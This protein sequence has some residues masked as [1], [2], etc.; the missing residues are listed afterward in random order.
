MWIPVDGHSE[1]QRERE[2]GHKNCTRKCVNDI[3]TD[4]QEKRGKDG[5]GGQDRRE[6]RG[7][8]EERR[9]DRVYIQDG[10]D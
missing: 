10:I 2:G 7:V 9:D 3:T 4:L 1:G 5:R 6:G 8:G